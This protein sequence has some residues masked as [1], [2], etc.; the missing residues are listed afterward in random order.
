MP[1]DHID[2]TWV[3][4]IEE[5]EHLRR[6]MAEAVASDERRDL[7]T[8]HEVSTVVN[9]PYHYNTHPSGVECIEVVRLCSYN[10]GNAIKYVW[11][12]EDKDGPRD[13]SKARWSLQDIM[14]SGHAHHLPHKAKVKLTHVISFEPVDTVRFKLFSCLLVGDL[15]GAINLIS[16]VIGEDDVTEA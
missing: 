16:E 3:P 14:S 4:E 10:M 12:H 1:N 8:G 11:R 13:L 9:H 15:R 5:M 7:T 6:D 2:P